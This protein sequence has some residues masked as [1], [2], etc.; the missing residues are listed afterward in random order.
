MSAGKKFHPSKKFIKG[1]IGVKDADL[2]DPE[3]RAIVAAARYMR[4]WTAFTF[5][6]YGAYSAIAFYSIYSGYHMWGLAL[7]STISLLTGLQFDINAV[8]N[9]TERRIQA[10]REDHEIKD[11]MQTLEKIKS[12]TPE[13]AKDKRH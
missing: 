8:V 12:T 13:A 5:L 4:N 6:K 9:E 11:F 7:I 2:F 10:A 3:T 1:K